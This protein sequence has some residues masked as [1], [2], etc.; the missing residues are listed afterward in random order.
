MAYVIIILMKLLG[1][2]GLNED[3]NLRW[4]WW[5]PLAWVLVTIGAFIMMCLG[6]NPF[7]TFRNA[8]RT[9]DLWNGI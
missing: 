4:Y 1:I 8:F 7:K 5:N 3:S 2:R 6:E 9:D